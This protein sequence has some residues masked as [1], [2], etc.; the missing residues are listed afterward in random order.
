MTKCD[1]NR[2][3]VAKSFVVSEKSRTFAAMEQQKWIITG[4]NRLTHKRE[5]LSR[6]MGEQEAA[7]RLQR[8]VANRRYQRYQPYVR[9][10]VERLEAVQLTFNFMPYEK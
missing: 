10:K 9:L 6:P 3:K 7:E 5:Q 4:V 8:E 2:K 1:Q